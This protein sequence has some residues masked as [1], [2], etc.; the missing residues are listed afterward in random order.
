[1]GIPVAEN[2]V[3]QLRYRLTVSRLPYINLQTS[4]T[5]DVDHKDPDHYSARTEDERGL[6]LTKDWT[7][8]EERKA[9]FK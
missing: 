4:V 6:T 8:E 2:S 9:K 7:V 3:T 5:M 1:M